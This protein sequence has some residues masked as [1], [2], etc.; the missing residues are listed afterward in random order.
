MA[1]FNLNEYEMVEDRLKKFWDDCPNGRI[2]TN[3]VHRTE[4]GTW[5]SMKTEI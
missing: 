3:V 1:K 5:V 2:E 4:D